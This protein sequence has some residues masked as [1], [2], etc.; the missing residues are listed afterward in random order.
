MLCQLKS[1]PVISGHVLAVTLCHVVLSLVKSSRV[2]AV[3][4]SHVPASQF[5]PVP[6]CPVPPSH[7]V[8]G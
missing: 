2:V 4:F 6:L 7:V 8:S 1:C 3:L 5:W